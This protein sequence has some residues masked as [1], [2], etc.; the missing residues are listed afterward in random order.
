MSSTTSECPVLRA[1]S[2]SE[3]IVGRLLKKNLIIHGK[4][5]NR[6][7]CVENADLLVPLINLVGAWDM[8]YCSIMHDPGWNLLKL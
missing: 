1:W 7:A 5:L 8:Q 6:D 4:T 2:E 3:I